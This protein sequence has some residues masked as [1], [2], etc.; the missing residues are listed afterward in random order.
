MGNTPYTWIRGPNIKKLSFLPT[1]IY[2]FKVI[3]NIPKV[4]LLEV[5]K[6][7]FLLKKINKDTQITFKN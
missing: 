1:F 2:S 7:S 4:F 5:D 3:L 6:R